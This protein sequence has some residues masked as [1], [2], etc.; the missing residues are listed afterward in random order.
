MAGMRPGI[1]LLREGTDTSQGKP[2]LISNINACAAVADM[3]RTTLGPRGMDKLMFDGRKVTISNDGATIMRM[4][5]VEHPAAKTLV[6]ISL[7]QDAE[8]GDG[9]TSVVLLAAEILT[10][11]K[12]L[13]EEGTHPQVVMRSVRRAAALGVA[14]IKEIAVPFEGEKGAEMILKCACTA[15][16]SKLIASHQ[17]LFGPMV[18]DAVRHLDQDL[19]DLSLVAIKKVPGGEVRQSFLVRGVA[20]KKTFSYAGFEQMTKKFKNP[21]I[22]LLNVELELKAEKEN[23]EVRITDPSQYQS[24][25]DA[26]WTV[27]Y[28][29]LDKC[30]NCGANIVLSKLPIGDLATQ[31][32][33]DRGLFCAGRVET[34]DMGRVSKATGAAVQTSVH[35][36]NDEILGTCE[37]FEE[38][39]VGDER[40]NLMTGCPSALTATIVLRGGS[41]QFIAES[42]RSIHDALMVVRRSLRSRSVVAGGGAV[43]MAVSRH[44]REVSR[45]IEGK[46]QLIVGAFARALEA[47]PRQLADN[48]G[49]DSTD[50]LNMLRTK[51][52][53][54]GGGG[55]TGVDI[56][57]GGVCDT[58]AANVWEPADNK[59]N[60]LAAAA[61]A[62]CVIL[63]I[64]ETVRNPRSQDPGMAPPGGGGGGAAGMMGGAMDIANNGQRT[65]TLG[66]GVKYMK[67]RGGG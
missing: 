1:I 35:G 42:E 53:A 17:D 28:D 30:I 20:F 13:V 4:L 46:G 12:S 38:V 14:K 26:E 67:G 41:E 25:V 58:F 15:L 59:C 63:S 21:K 32:F 61:E 62:A 7:S 44:L 33:A 23:A 16:N 9:T 66:K 31:Y 11:V 3:V 60:S 5:E 36:F 56:E 52:A 48:A 10:Q 18:V 40:F 54:K 57:N 43:E 19:A 65:G 29:K 49:F 37:N 22:L 8:V 64:D 50:V 45:T 55:W 34:G 24:I 2:Q 6:D 51:H 39:R 47:V 27:I